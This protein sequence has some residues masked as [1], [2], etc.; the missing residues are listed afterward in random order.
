MPFSEGTHRLHWATAPLRAF[1][2]LIV[3]FV[4]LGFPL[5][6][7][8]TPSG[9]AFELSPEVVV[10]FVAVT[11][12][13]GVIASG[14]GLWAWLALRFRVDG[15]DLVVET[16]VLR[17]RRRRIP[18]SRVQA[19][20]VVRPLVTRVF[21]LAEV[22][23][24]LAGGEQSEIALRYLGRDTAQRLRAE[25][26]ARAAGLPGHT[27]EAPERPLW[28][29][30]FGALLGSLVLRLPVI[31]T[32]ILFFVSLVLMLLWA[33][34]GMLA[35]AVPALLGLIRAV[36]AP[37]VMYANFRAAMSPDGV[38]LRYGLLET[39]MQTLPPGRVQ[40]VSVVEP[41]IWRGFGWARV[42]VTIAGYAGERQAL[43]ST[44]LPVAPRAVAMAMV[45][46]VFPGADVDAVPLL[47]ASDKAVALDRPDAAGTDDKVFV[48]RH[49]WLCRRTDVIAHARAQSVRL[50]VNPVQRL[51]G[52]ATVH[53]DAPPGP[54]QVAAADRDLGEARAIVDSAAFRAQAARRSGGD[55]ARWATRR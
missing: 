18:L 45:A 34:A 55:P 26:L 1:V 43:S 35:V 31:G 25:L 24:E 48:T 22:R 41:A 46:Q 51:L 50:T 6:L 7:T 20:D 42:D 2:F 36:A 17:K 44:L 23:V 14:S 40:A 33:E 53:V 54:V 12:P 16:G 27:P 52:L 8:Q 10:R 11:V 9:V 49:G 32:A 15:S 4:L 38:R 3:Y 21:S 29:V 37:L 5:L 19:I 28:R 13:M 47:P 39:R 30:P